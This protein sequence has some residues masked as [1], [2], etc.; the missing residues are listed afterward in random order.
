VAVD[1]GTFD[2]PTARVEASP[3]FDLA[4]PRRFIYPAIL[5]LLLERPNHGYGY[6][7]LPRLEQ[8]CFGHVDRPAVYRALSQLEDDGLVES[9]QQ[10]NGGHARRVYRITLKGEQVLR[11]WMEVIKEEHDYLGE[12][13]RRYQASGG[14]EAVLA[15]VSGGWPASLRFGWSPLTPTPRS[16]PQLVTLTA[17]TARA[18]D[19]AGPLGESEDRSEEARPA[20]I[21]TSE[22]RGSR[23]VLDPERS[24][25]LVEVRST[26]GPLAF[27][28]IG[29]RG[30][31]E[32]AVAGQTLVTD[33]PPAAYVEID[34]TG[35]R[36]GNSVYD[37]ELLRRIEARRYPTA[38]MKLRDC[39]SIGAESLYGVGGELTF[40]GVTRSATGTVSVTAAGGR[41]VVSGEQDFDIRDFSIP[42]PTVLMLR[43]YPDVR[44]HL[45]VEAE[46]E[47]SS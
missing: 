19:A 33:L 36:S 47:D 9:R 14:A 43:I 30:W 37:S 39:R 41:L 22:C 6:A 17:P 38:T 18:K 32:V 5:L 35:L 46:L 44:V 13:L 27:G 15:E 12:V 24:V 29:I 21:G 4:P 40:H 26:V 7:L 8:F 34:V 16:A 42:S 25:V 10:T 2:T 45:H 23:Y 28:A 20:A 31:V 11:R 1:D 3:R